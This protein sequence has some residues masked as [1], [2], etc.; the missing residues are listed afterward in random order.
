MLFGN[1]PELRKDMLGFLTQCVRDYGDFV[2]IWLG[3]K[4]VIV[5]GHP[6]LV[7]RVLV[8]GQHV[9]GKGTAERAFHQFT[10]DGLS[11]L[12]GDVWLRRRRLMQ[13]PFRSECVVANG[14]SMVE[15]AERMAMSWRDGVVF[16]IH[17]LMRQLTLEIVARMLFRLE[18]PGGAAPLA[19]AM[20]AAIDG[21]IGRMGSLLV[22]LPDTVPTPANLRLR[23]AISR[24]DASIYH[25]IDQGRARSDNRGDLLSLLLQTQDG[26]S[27]HGL[28]DQEIR[29]ELV[30]VLVA[31]HET[32]ALALTWCWYLLSQHP[33]V[34]A[35]LISELEAVLEGRRP[36]PADVSQ[37]RYTTMVILETLRLFPPSPTIGRDALA[38]CDLGGYQVPQGAAVVASQ[39]VVHRDPRFFDDPEKFNPHRWADGLAARLPRFAYFPFGAGPRQCIGSGL[40]MM[41]IILVLSTLARE[42]HFSLLPE[43]RISIRPTPF[44]HPRHGL[45]MMLHRRHDRRITARQAPG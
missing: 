22:L 31:G 8:T 1:A 6:D 20:S 15:C 45:K 26:L 42:F 12:N 32:T 17:Q 25:L 19:A 28:S 16:E 36:T 41:E 44:L 37:L 9:F 29:D 39:W 4:L 34:E 30:D 27:E 33:E 14:Q 3:P 23:R 40:A 35:L 11:V 21:I 38:D 13:P 43:Q 7:G 10:G 18:I 24:V 2:P 5:V